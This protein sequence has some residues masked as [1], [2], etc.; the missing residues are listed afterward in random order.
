[1]L[2]SSFVITA[3]NADLNDDGKNDVRDSKQKKDGWHAH[4]VVLGGPL[5]LPAPISTFCVISISDAPKSGIS[6]QGTN[7]KVNV[8]NFAITRS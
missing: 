8:K 2:L 6:I 4:N 7:I 1:L 5:P 3:H